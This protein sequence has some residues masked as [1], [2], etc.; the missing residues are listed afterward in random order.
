MK[1]T[2]SSLPQNLFDILDLSEKKIEF[3]SRYRTW[4]HD[5]RVILDLH[6][7]NL[8]ASGDGSAHDGRHDNLCMNRR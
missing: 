3:V 6:P 8:S 2:E 7:D 4:V 1:I 5:P